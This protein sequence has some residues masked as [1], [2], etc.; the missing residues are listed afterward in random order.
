MRRWS[1]TSAAS[2]LCILLLLLLLQQ[3]LH[4][5][6]QL[7][8]LLRRRADLVAGLQTVMGA[9]DAEMEAAAAAFVASRGTSDPDPVPGLDLSH[10]LV[11]LR[12]ETPGT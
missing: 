12:G 7:Q 2:R 10:G 4:G 11:P 6:E 1:G 3:A 5:Q 8:T 9:Q